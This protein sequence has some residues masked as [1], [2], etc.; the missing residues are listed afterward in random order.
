MIIVFICIP[1]KLPKK[2]T[3][4][5]LSNFSFFLEKYFRKN[6]ITLT[7]SDEPGSFVVDKVTIRLS[8]M[9]LVKLTT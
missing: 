1:L 9:S 4:C 5:P 8:E 7:A 3:R 2:R 6:T